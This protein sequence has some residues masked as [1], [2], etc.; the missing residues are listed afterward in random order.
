MKK[1]INLSK[2]LMEY[3]NGD[4]QT[5]VISGNMDIIR[6]IIEEKDNGEFFTL[7]VSFPRFEFISYI[8]GIYLSI[9][10]WSK[11]I[12]GS[13]KHENQLLDN[14]KFNKFTY[15]KK[16]NFIRNKLIED[17][18]KLEMVQKN[19]EIIESLPIKI[20]RDMNLDDLLN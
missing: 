12:D 4:D 10:L 17:N 20:K 8:N 19:R 2:Y 14:Q 6:F 9:D 3:M 7:D 11:Y 16:L 13:W 15:I 18:K 5:W 1:I